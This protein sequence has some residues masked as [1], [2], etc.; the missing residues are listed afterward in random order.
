MSHSIAFAGRNSVEVILF[1]A[2]L[3][4]CYQ[5]VHPRGRDVGAFGFAGKGRRPDDHV[6][7]IVVL[8][9]ILCVIFIVIRVFLVISFVLVLLFCN[10]LIL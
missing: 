10:C 4:V 9:H 6:L 5:I 2:L 1:L 7:Y 8:F 3:F